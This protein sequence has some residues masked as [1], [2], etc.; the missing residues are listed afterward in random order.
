MATESQITRIWDFPGGQVAK[1]ALP[2]EQTQVWY[3]VRE[4]DP[5]CKWRYGNA[6]RKTEDP[7]CC[8]QDLVQPKK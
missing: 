1:T 3:P 5:T 6:T 4:L 8:N 7:V 2:M